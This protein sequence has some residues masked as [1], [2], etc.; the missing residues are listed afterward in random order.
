MEG[1][2]KF[3]WGFLTALGIGNIAK[4]AISE[5]LE[6]PYEAGC[7]DNHRLFEKDL[8]KVRF[9][10]MTQKELDR[11]IRKGKYRDYSPPSDYDLWIKRIEK[12]IEIFPNANHTMDKVRLD[13]VKQQ[14]A[15]G[16][17]LDTSILLKYKMMD[18]YL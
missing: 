5:S 18:E 16:W 12:Y 11:N 3:V 17:K 4:N 10:E 15:N 13:Y 1:Q 9:G 6:K 7:I 14:K 8:D 2:V